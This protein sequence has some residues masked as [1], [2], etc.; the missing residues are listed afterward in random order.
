MMIP[1]GMRDSKKKV[2]ETLLLGDGVF[3]S[4][5]SAFVFV[6]AS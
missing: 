4:E 6:C 5:L 3:F 1:K 2:C